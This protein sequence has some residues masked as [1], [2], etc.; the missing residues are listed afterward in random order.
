MVV[1]ICFSLL[2]TDVEHLFMYLLVICMSFFGKL[3]IQILCPF[4]NWIC[5]VSVVC[6]LLNCMSYLYILC[7]N[8][9][10]GL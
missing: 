1:L 5:F 4:F 8:P 9:L 3:S 2:I 7:I 10:P 6:L